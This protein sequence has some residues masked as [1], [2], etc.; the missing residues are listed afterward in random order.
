MVDYTGVTAAS[1]FLRINIYFQSSGAFNLDWYLNKQ[2]INT[3][4]KDIA[5]DANDNNEEQ[6]KHSSHCIHSNIFDQ[7]CF[8]YIDYYNA[9]D[10][11]SYE[12]VV[13]L[14]DNPSVH[15]TMSVV[16]I[17]PSTDHFSYAMLFFV[18][19]VKK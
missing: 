2:K 19:F 9:K 14:K 8:L 5:E 15:A 1:N 16:V 11:G 3:G 10:T 6:S 13:T 17:M 4:G 18:N 12:A 7:E